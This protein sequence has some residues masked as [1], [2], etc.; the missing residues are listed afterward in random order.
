M[1]TNST[2]ENAFL[3]KSLQSG[4]G[5]PPVHSSTTGLPLDRALK[6]A[7]RVLTELA[8]RCVKIEFAGSVR[9]RCPV[10]N[11]IDFVAIPK[12]RE[13]FRERVMRHCSLAMKSDG[14]TPIGD[15]DNMLV[16]NMQNGVQ[17]DIWFAKEAR[18]ELFRKIPSNWG[19]VLLCRTGSKQ[20]NIYLAQLARSM[21]YQWQTMIGLTQAGNW[22]AG[23]TEE[24]IFRAL[25][26]PYVEPEKRDR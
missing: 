2:H 20:H 22:V 13:D 14:V 18:Q 11:D 4:I 10:C 17:L 8:P 23:E 7:T 5:V 16:V 6:L 24:E 1:T 9:R 15:G 26:M 3:P 25:Q 19:T 12:S 21:G